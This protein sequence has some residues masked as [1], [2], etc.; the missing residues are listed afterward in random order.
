MGTDLAVL[1]ED[2]I[3]WDTDRA[4]ITSAWTLSF[5]LAC[6]RE[7]TPPI[8]TPLHQPLER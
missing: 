8:P 2:L 5:H 7:L 4:R 1:L 3:W 6:H